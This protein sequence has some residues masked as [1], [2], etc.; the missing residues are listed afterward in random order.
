MS[1]K[2]TFVKSDL[3]KEMQGHFQKIPN[4]RIESTVEHIFKYLG[5]KLAETQSIEIRQFGRFKIKEMKER[6]ARNPKTGEKLTVPGG[7]KKIAWKTSKIL[8]QRI[9]KEPIEE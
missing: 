4:A 8:N 1:D 3:V 9:N 2:K 5:Q 7:K 6:V